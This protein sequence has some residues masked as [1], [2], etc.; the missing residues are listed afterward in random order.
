MA[1]RLELADAVGRAF[2]WIGSEAVAVDGGLGWCDG[3]ALA[4]DL[5]SGTA[6]V[7]TG[8]AEAT[9]AGLDTG[10][11]AA[12]ARDRLLHLAHRGPDADSPPEDGPGR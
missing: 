12:G 10:P 6:G 2:G 8:C 11:V 9:A 7:L 3:G 4:D 1:A 5:Y